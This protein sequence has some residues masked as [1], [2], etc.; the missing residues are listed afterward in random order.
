VEAQKDDETLSKMLVNFSPSSRKS[1]AGASQ[2][3]E[4]LKSRGK[5]RMQAWGE[6]VAMESGFCC[7]HWIA[8]QSK[9]IAF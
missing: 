3:L 8:G 6:N 4:A 1:K 9:M 2:S 5:E 7:C